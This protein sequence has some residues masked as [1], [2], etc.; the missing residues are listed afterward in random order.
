MRKETISFKALFHKRVTHRYFLCYILHPLFKPT[1]NILSIAGLP[2]TVESEDTDVGG[3]GLV[4]KLR[5]MTWSLLKQK[6]GKPFI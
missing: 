3:E 1:C 5:V 6:M 4:F 2:L